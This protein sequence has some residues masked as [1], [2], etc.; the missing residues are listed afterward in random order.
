V[1]RYY[2]EAFLLLAFYANYTHICKIVNYLQGFCI[3]L[4]SVIFLWYSFFNLQKDNWSKKEFSR[5]FAYHYL[6]AELLKNK[7][8]NGNVLVLFFTRDNIFF[9]KNIYSSR[10]LFNF[11]SFNNEYEQNFKNF[12]NNTNIKHIVFEDQSNIPSCIE[13]N[14]Y[15]EINFKIAT[16]NFL[17]K[18]KEQ[19]FK[20]ARIVKND[21]LFT[22][23]ESFK[24]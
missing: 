15:D 12:L 23:D 2:L 11:N 6:N 22:K 18:H 4:F 14:I 16:R 13:L 8:I 3:I 1:P 24:N 10:Y 5:K 21:C 7:E 9:E 20:I 17:S 19:N